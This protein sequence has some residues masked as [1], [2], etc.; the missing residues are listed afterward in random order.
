M[1][2]LALGKFGGREMNYH[3]DLDLIFLYEA[4]GQTVP[5]AES[6]AG[7]ST[8]NQHFFSE[9]GQR[10]IKTASRSERLRPALCDRRAA[11]S[12]RPKRRGGDQFRRVFRGI[13][14]QAADSF[15]SGKPLCKAQAGVWFTAGPAR[16]TMAA[17]AAAAFN[18]RWQRTDAGE[19]R[20][21]RQ[22]LEDTAAAAGDLKRGPGGL[23]DIEFLV[24]MLQLKHAGQIPAAPRCRLRL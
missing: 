18:H 5:D 7:R 6:P 4:D 20:R 24:Q 10:I 23:V 3:S 15:G 13:S 11:S 21:M 14:P 19:I 2:I 16:L 22:R 9:L 1:V 12:D 8:T 17:V